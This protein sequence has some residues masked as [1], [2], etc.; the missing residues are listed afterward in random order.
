MR[1]LLKV[2]MDVEAGNRAIRDGSLG[3]R[4]TG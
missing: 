1:M 2:Q 3:R 4:S